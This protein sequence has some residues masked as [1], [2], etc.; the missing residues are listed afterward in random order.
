MLIAN[1]INFFIKTVSYPWDYRV[2]YI[3]KSSGSN[4]A[5]AWFSS[6]YKIFGRFDDDWS[7]TYSIGSN[8]NS[9][10]RVVGSNYTSPYIGNYSG[11]TRFGYQSWTPSDN[12]FTSVAD[13]VVTFRKKN[14]INGLIEAFEN[15]NPTNILEQLY[16]DLTPDQL[17]WDGID[18]HGYGGVDPATSEQVGY[19]GLFKA[20]RGVTYGD[21]YSEHAGPYSFLR[22]RIYDYLYV[23]RH[24]EYAQYDIRSQHIIP[25]VYLGQPA[26]YDEFNDVFLEKFETGDFI[27][28]P[29]VK[30]D[31]SDII[32]T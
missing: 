9:D 31:G 27:A 3:E 32:Y 21:T 28:G 16:N 29:K 5:G 23:T 13:R 7:C 4:Y 8:L 30:D 26:F 12:C 6:R 18:N 10:H 11:H 24:P 2:A 1:R 19:I 25:C 22:T 17:Y 14:R 20:V 15:I